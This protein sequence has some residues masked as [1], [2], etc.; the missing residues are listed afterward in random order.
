MLVMLCAAVAA[1]TSLPG[2]AVPFEVVEDSGA[3]VLAEN[4]PT[5][6]LDAGAL[7]G[8]ELVAV[9]G[10]PMDDAMVV[11]RRVAEGPA[12]DVQLRFDTLA[13]APK[14]GEAAA[15]KEV[16]LV[17][18]RAPLVHVERVAK[19]PWPS[20][21]KPASDWKEDWTG[22]P[23]LLDESRGTWTFEVRDGQWYRVGAQDVTDRPI[24]PVFWNLTD[25]NWIIDS[26]ASLTSGNRSFAR[27]RFAKAARVGSFRGTV[28]DHLLVET[29]SGID[30]FAIEYPSGTP[31]LPSCQPRVPETCLSSG[32]EILT[33]L[34]SRSGAKAEAL[35]LF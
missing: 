28:G 29:S 14:P 24:P 21:F 27:D 10:L 22:S 7:P 13:E 33:D 20:D 32:L 23:I 30:V 5:E 16:V 34:E 6:L 11:Q 15:P 1:A 12:R 31:S 25:A 19:V 4:L 17:A 2:I 9:D 3:W 18:T 26:G 8:W 35:R